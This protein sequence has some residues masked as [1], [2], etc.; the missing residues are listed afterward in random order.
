MKKIMKNSK[1]I[2]AIIALIIVV[3][4]VIIFTLGFNYELKYDKNNTIQIYLEEQFQMEEVRNITKEIFKNKKVIV[5]YVEEFKDTVNITTTEITEEEKSA[6]IQ[7]INEKYGLEYVSEDFEIVSNSKIKL[8][9]MLKQYILPIIIVAVIIILYFIIM[10]KRIGIIKII[11]KS[12]I[13]IFISQVI[14]FS[15]TAITRF[16]IGRLTLTLV[17][18]T[19]LISIVCLISKFEK[20]KNNKRAQNKKA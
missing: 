3:G 12:V 2:Y 13:T 17:I 7:K 15:L 4:A 11:T 5:E 9:D 16:P 8:I 19:F 18:S 1:I 6:L 14:L 20:E 10:Y